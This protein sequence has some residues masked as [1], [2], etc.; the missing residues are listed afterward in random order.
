MLLRRWNDLPNHMKNDSVQKYYDILQKKHLI[1]FFKSLF[2]FAIGIILLAILSPAFLIISIAVKID[3]PGPVLFRQIRVTQYG[4]RFW[5]YKFRTMVPNADRIGP[6][7]AAGNDVR[8]TKVGRVLRKKHLDEFP[9]LL[10]IIKGDMS[11]VGTRPEI[12]KFVEQYTDEMMA[13]LLLRAGITSNASIQ[14]KDEEKM[15]KFP[16]TEEVYLHIILPEK[17]KVNL[18]SIEKYSIFNDISVMFRTVIKTTKDA[19]LKKVEDLVR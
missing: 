12:P 8:V 18:K 19:R 7:I 3:S 5:I 9:Q 1:L 14:Y 17:M 13:T 11:F 4:R 15:M 10:N 2:D 16:D 6:Q